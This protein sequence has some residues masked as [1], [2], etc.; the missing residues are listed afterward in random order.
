M[1]HCGDC[2]VSRKSFN[3]TIRYQDF[4]NTGT[5]GFFCSFNLHLYPVVGLDL[6]RVTWGQKSNQAMRANSILGASAPSSE[7]MCAVPSWALSNATGILMDHQCHFLKKYTVGWAVFFVL[8]FFETGSGRAPGATGSFVVF[9]LFRNRPTIPPIDS[10]RVS[11]SNIVR[12]WWEMGPSMLKKHP[13]LAILLA[14]H[15]IL[16]LS[17]MFPLAVCSTY[18]S[19]S[20]H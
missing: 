16:L 20:N 14:Y 4:K 19:I 2:G 12:N 18:P 3:Y 6:V 13:I 7:P 5:T 9:C 11:L 10:E 15:S 1:D 8:F 17:F